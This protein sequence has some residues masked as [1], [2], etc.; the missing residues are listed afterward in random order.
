MLFIYSN[1][2]FDNFVVIPLLT[3]PPRVVFKKPLFIKKKLGVLSTRGT[4]N[5]NEDRYRSVTLELPTGT[6]LRTM[7]READRAYFG[8]FDGHGG[9]L[10]SE[11]LAEQLHQKIETVTLDDFPRILSTLRGYGG[12]FRRFRIPSTLEGL[13]DEKTGTLKS[14]VSPDD[15]SLD[16]RLTLA[17][18][19]ADVEC[20]DFLRDDGPDGY[21]EGSTGSIAIIEPHDAKPFWD[22][23]RYEIV[24]GH[25]GDTRILLCDASTGQVVTLTTGD[26]H[27]SNPNEQ[28]RLRKY[29][30]FVTTDS[31]GDDR[32][33]GMLATSRA[34][35]DAKLKR[36]GV[37]SEPDIVRHT[38]EKDNPAAFLVLVTDGLTSVMS[39]QEIVDV[40]KTGADP[41]MSARKL[42]DIADQYGSEDNCTAMVVR[43]KDWG[44]RMHD[45]TH[46]LREYRLANS[47]MSSRQS[48]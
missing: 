27:P 47:S 36:Y 16:Q 46:D 48:W 44:T 17:F 22:S 34:F 37:S 9:P 8:V 18:L 43:L 35:G 24:I 10:V 15:L 45:L 41:T 28:D 11:W 1:L 42:V 13:V 40:V 38:I 4:R 26:H 7:K 20:L 31:W 32:I 3:S 33:L 19:D 12:Y 23:E 29:A 14:N 39:D 5:H 30:G 21:H 2:F 6:K 25:V